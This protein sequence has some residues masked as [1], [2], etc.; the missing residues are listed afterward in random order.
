VHVPAHDARLL[1][2]VRRCSMWRHLRVRLRSSWQH[3]RG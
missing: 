2:Q 3:G 1:R